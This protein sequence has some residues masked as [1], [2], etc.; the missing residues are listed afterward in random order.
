MMCVLLITEPVPQY[1][2]ASFAVTHSCLLTI[3]N[4]VVLYYLGVDHNGSGVAALLEVARQ[5]R[6]KKEKL[7]HTV[8]FLSSDG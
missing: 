3:L 6:S 2:I 5:L 4:K 7:K 8:I 1:C